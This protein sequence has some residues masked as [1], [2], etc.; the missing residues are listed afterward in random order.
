M[1]EIINVIVLIAA[2]AFAFS[3]IGNTKKHQKLKPHN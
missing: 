1:F 3:R 2:I